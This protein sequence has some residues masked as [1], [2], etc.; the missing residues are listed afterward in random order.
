MSA[1]AANDT[2]QGETKTAASVETTTEEET[3]MKTTSVSF[4]TNLLSRP[5]HI[6]L[7]VFFKSV[8]LSKEGIKRNKY[9]HH[10]GDA[11]TRPPCLH[12]RCE[13]WKFDQCADCGADLGPERLAKEQKRERKNIAKDVQSTDRGEIT[14]CFSSHDASD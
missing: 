5:E 3:K 9:N 6:P 13:N 8:R 14:R 2:S 7:S 4:Y 12:G 11:A 10:K 1:L